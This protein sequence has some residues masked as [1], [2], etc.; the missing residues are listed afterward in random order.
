MVG[1]MSIDK[2]PELL[3]LSQVSKILNVHPNTLR[4]WDTNGQ[5]KAVR[6]GVKKIRRYRKDDIL[7]LIK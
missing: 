5:L 7:K 2:M 1:N 6:V 4:N 3:T